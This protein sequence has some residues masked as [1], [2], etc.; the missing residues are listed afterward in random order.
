MQ[1]ILIKPV[2]KLGKVGE[3][4]NVKNGYGRNFL[5]PLGFA[6]RATKENLGK[7]ATLQN[8]LE[9]KNSQEKSKMEAAA[10]ALNDKHLIF[11]TQSGADDRLF[12]SI[13][14]KLLASS[15]SELSGYK[16]NY[17]NIIIDSPIK[18][19]GVF[20]IQVMLHPEIFASVLIVVAKSDSEAQDALR[21]YKE[22]GNKKPESEKEQELDMVEAQSIEQY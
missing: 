20:K 18:F 9:A 4:V 14:L 22:A 1:V 19:N 3:I 17:S 2:R 15:L 12:G 21:E 10:K 5:M 7:F 11:V 16:L 6:I 8:E 13:S